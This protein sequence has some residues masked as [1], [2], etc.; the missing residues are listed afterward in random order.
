MSIDNLMSEVNEVLRAYSYLDEQD[1]DIEAEDLPSLIS[2]LLLLRI[3]THESMKFGI[4]YEEVD[5]FCDFAVEHIYQM[6][7]KGQDISEIDVE[8]IVDAY[9]SQQEGSKH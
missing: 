7:N 6:D 9:R 5:E 1:E 4:K 8:D 2:H 3:F